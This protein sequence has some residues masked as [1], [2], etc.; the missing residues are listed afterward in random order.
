LHEASKAA[1]RSAGK[2]ALQKLLRRSR[3]VKGYGLKLVSDI[4][5]RLHDRDCRSGARSSVR[6]AR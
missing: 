6:A 5:C 4:G 1:G 3:F 2:A